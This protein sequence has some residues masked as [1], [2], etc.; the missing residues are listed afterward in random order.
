MVHFANLSVDCAPTRE[1]LTVGVK[2]S[3]PPYLSQLVAS[4][5]RWA[6]IG[7]LQEVKAR[8]QEM[9]IWPLTFPG[10]FTQ[11][12]LRPPKGVLLY[13][14]PGT[15]KTMLAAAVATESSSNFI[16]ATLADLLHSGYGD[17][18]KHIAEL[19][20]RAR[21]AAPAIVFFDEMQALFPSRD[22]S[23]AFERKLLAQ[24]MR[25]MDES[26]QV[27]VIGATN[28]PS[29]MD[30]ALLRRLDHLL[31]V[32]PPEL[33][34]RV[35]ILELQRLRS[36]WEGVETSWLAEATA[37]FTGADLR[38]LCQR[39]GRN[40]ILRDEN[41]TAL[42]ESDFREALRT[43]TPSVSPA[44]LLEFKEFERSRDVSL[45]QQNRTNHT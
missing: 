20:R 36:R 42:C 32:P 43:T 27:I 21:A 6:D 33:S 14:P 22:S 34:E 30:L 39:A 11:T 26:P 29:A 35:A 37:G 2:L 15:G 8:L 17:S 40:A 16:A 28:L 12:Q 44:D 18:E 1:E 41:A 3:R 45:R 24:L 25:E 31:Y 38:G 4:V 23:E 10:L 13:G 7:G 19:F 5:V 9:V